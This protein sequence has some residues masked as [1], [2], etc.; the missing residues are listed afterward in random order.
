MYHFLKTTSALLEREGWFLKKDIRLLPKKGDKIT[1][2]LWVT[3]VTYLGNSK[4]F[5]SNDLDNNWTAILDTKP[6]AEKESEGVSPATKPH[7]RGKR[8]R[9]QISVGRGTRSGASRKDATP[10][11]DATPGTNAT[12][13][14]KDATTDATKGATPRKKGKAA[15]K[16]DPTPAPASEAA[17]D[18]EAAAPAYVVCSRDHAD[19]LGLIEDRDFETLD[20]LAK[21]AFD[22]VASIQTPAGTLPQLTLLACNINL[23]RTHMLITCTHE[24]CVSTMRV[25]DVAHDACSGDKTDWSDFLTAWR[26]KGSKRGLSDWGERIPLNKTRKQRWVVRGICRSVV[27]KGLDKYCRFN[28][29]PTVV[30]GVAPTAGHRR[31]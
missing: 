24:R 12:P 29:T 28:G 4:T 16:A 31:K 18:S 27:L 20:I 9:S 2:K 13:G 30:T 25:H 22:N 15:K 11:K 5:R 10:V 19:V 7:S 23:T 14:K 1:R 26:G 6:P 17:S 21:E 3:E 8:R